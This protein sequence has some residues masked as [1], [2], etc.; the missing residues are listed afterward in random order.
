MVTLGALALMRS[1]S[2]T[3]WLAPSSGRS[4][5]V[6]DVITTWLSSSFA[7]SSGIVSNSLSSTSLTSCGF[8][9]STEQKAQRRVQWLPR[10]MNVRCLFDQHS[11]IFG[12]FA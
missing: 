9:V 3:K 8:F 4:S 5:R 12:H 7:T 1:T 11:K 6:T 2:F 10:I